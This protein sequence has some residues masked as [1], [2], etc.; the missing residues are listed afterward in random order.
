MPKKYTEIIKT[1]EKMTVKEL[2]DFVGELEEKFGP[3]AITTAPA[4]EA[5]AQEAKSEYD[6]ELIGVGGSAISVIKVVK[7]I[8]DLGLMETKKMVD[9]APAIIKEKVKKEEAEEIKK[10]LEEAGATVELK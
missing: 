7:E 1:I 6:I 5:P 3:V 9:S 8:T 2:A 10:K 4:Q